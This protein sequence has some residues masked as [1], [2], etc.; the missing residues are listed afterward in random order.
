MPACPAQPCFQKRLPYSADLAERAEREVQRAS[1]LAMQLANLQRTQHGEAQALRAAEGG[2]AVAAS[3]H[4]VRACIRFRSISLVPAAERRTLRRS[5]HAAEEELAASRAARG[6]LEVARE[7][8]AAQAATL[9]AELLQAQREAAALRQ[10]VEAAEAAR[11]QVRANAAG[12]RG[13]P[14]DD[15]PRCL[16]AADSV[17]ASFLSCP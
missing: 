11:A 1:R 17:K 5:L 8:M 9:D 16:R 4:A 2:R 14:L 15:L 10:Q 3:Q 12:T 7:E 6:Q 13:L